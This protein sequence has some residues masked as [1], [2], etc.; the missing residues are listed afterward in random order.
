[1]HSPSHQYPTAICSQ[2]PHL[3]SPCLIKNLLRIIR[4]QTMKSTYRYYKLNHK[5]HQDIIQLIYHL[6]HKHLKS[7]TRISSSFQFNNHSIFRTYLNHHLIQ[8]Q[9]ESLIW[10]RY[11]HCKW[12]KWLLKLINLNLRIVLMLKGSTL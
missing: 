3:T 1:M 8:T 5:I 2:Y 11:Y 4:P 10:L 12:I 7:L 9:T 6:I